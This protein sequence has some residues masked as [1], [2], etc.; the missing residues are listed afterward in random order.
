MR[1]TSPVRLEFFD[2]FPTF[3]NDKAVVVRYL[4]NHGYFVMQS[5][6]A[7]TFRQISTIFNDFEKLN[8][9]LQN[10]ANLEEKIEIKRKLLNKLIANDR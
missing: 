9:L 3:I 6:V 5:N 4:P 1:K 8:F 7:S 10:Q 2:D